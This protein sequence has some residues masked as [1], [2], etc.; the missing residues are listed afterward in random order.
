LFSVIHIEQNNSIAAQFHLSLKRFFFSSSF[1]M[2]Y[3][4]QTKPIKQ[5]A[6]SIVPA[7]DYD[8]YT[9]IKV[10]HC[11]TINDANV[12]RKVVLTFCPDASDKDR[13]LRTLSDFLARCDALSLNAND[14]E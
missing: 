2:L 4:D 14:G 5:P 12:V 9:T 13:L 1:N 10:D 3:N 11:S 8:Q 6:I 7:I